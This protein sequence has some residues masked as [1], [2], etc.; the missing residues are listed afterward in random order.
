MK[1]KVKN[2]PRSILVVQDFRQLIIRIAIEI[3]V[4]TANELIAN[5]VTADMSVTATRRGPQ[6]EICNKNL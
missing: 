3:V 1:E 5:A 6:T 4:A 2:T